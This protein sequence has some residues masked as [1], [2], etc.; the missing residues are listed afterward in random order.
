MKNFISVSV[1]TQSFFTLTV[2]V[3]MVPPDCSGHGLCCHGGVP[4][5]THQPEGLCLLGLTTSTCTQR[6]QCIET[7]A[8]GYWDQRAV[9]DADLQRCGVC[10]LG[11]GPEGVCTSFGGPE[12]PGVQVAMI[13]ETVGTSCTHD[14]QVEDPHTVCE[15]QAGGRDIYVLPAL[16]ETPVVAVLRSRGQSD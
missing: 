10:K 14:A 15:M 13:P 4:C 7:N 11:Y 2:N 5:H 1:S 9:T 6:C 16:G 3:N 8:R 12:Y